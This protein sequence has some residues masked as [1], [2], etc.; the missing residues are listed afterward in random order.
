MSEKPLRNLPWQ[1]SM[2]W[3]SSTA[4]RCFPWRRLSL[5]VGAYLFLPIS[6]LLSAFLVC[7]PPEGRTVSL[8]SQ[9]HAECLAHNRHS[10]NVWRMSAWKS[11]WR[12][13]A[14]PQGGDGLSNGSSARLRTGLLTSPLGPPPS[15]LCASP[16]L[17]VTLLTGRVIH[18]SRKR[19]RKMRHRIAERRIQALLATTIPYFLLEYWHL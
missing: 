11:R 18:E 4:C 10:V 1:P 12:K 17:L 15:L 8:L 9:L 7:K 6:L 3:I 14:R 19:R 5:P 16:K 13:G 2:W